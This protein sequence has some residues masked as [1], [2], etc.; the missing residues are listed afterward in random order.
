MEYLFA[1]D[2]VTP[3]TVRAPG[4]APPDRTHASQRPRREGRDGNRAIPK[5]ACDTE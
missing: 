5:M 1:T 2:G 3:A 4:Q